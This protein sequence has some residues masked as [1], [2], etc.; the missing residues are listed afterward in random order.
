M[1][2]TTTT[3]TTAFTTATTATTTTT[4]ILRTEI[5]RVCRDCKRVFYK[6][7]EAVIRVRSRKTD[8]NGQGGVC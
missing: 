5:I 8:R 6:R 2:Y 3:T 7:A 1:I 4:C